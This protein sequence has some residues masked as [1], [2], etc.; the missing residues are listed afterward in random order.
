M[1]EGNGTGNCFDCLA[2]PV[3]K[4]LPR[5]P[6]IPVLEATR[7]LAVNGTDGG[8]IKK[9]VKPIRPTSSRPASIA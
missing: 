2:D 1:S 9:P 5:P 7:S 8:C 3:L 6:R 4:L